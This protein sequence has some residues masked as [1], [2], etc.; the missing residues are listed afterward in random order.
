MSIENAVRIAPNFELLA[1]RIKRNAKGPSIAFDASKEVPV[2]IDQGDVL[3]AHELHLTGSLTTDGTPAGTVRT[4]QPWDLASK[5]RVIAPGGDIINASGQMLRVVDSL[6]SSKL[7]DTNDVSATEHTAAATAVPYSGRLTIHYTEPKASPKPMG[8]LNLRSAGEGAFKI[9]VTWASG[10]TSLV[11]GTDSANTVPPSITVHK[12]CVEGYA[13]VQPHGY[14]LHTVKSRVEQAEV[15]ALNPEKPFSLT[16][17]RHLHF[18]V[19]I[20][21][22]GSTLALSEAPLTETGMIRVKVGG[23][24]QFEMEVRALRALQ[25]EYFPTGTDLTGVLLIPFLDTRGAELAVNTQALYLPQTEE[26]VLELPTTATATNEIEIGE[27]GRIDPD[28][29]AATLG[30]AAP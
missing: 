6:R 16:R 11:D 20:L 10:I 28:V 5:I 18:I 21:R 23:V 30:V 22:Q 29:A 8:L 7:P 12:R 1:K 13:Y 26:C 17:G 3:M 4:G 27:V 9:A 15:R 19:L 25:K 2:N 14:G 24:P